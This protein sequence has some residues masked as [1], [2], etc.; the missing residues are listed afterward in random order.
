VVPDRLDPTIEAAA[1]FLVSE[2]LTNVAKHAQADAVRVDIT[3]TDGTLAVTIADNGV[4]GAIPRMA[5][6]CG[7]WSIASPLLAGAW[8]SAVH[9]PRACVCA[10]TCP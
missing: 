2:A 8:K 7:A 6:A 10:L 1:Y 9:L 3:A 4:G 5:P